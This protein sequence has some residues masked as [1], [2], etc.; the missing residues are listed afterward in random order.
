MGVVMIPKITPHGVHYINEEQADKIPVHEKV[1]DR[2]STLIVMYEKQLT[3]QDKLIEKL[4]Q[5]NRYSEMMLSLT[6]I[7]LLIRGA[8]DLLF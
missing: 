5:K 1:I 2:Y 8:C 3:I 4:Q 7:I 6:L